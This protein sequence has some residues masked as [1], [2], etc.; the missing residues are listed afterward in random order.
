M[1][2]VITDRKYTRLRNGEQSNYLLAAKDDI[3]TYE[4][5]LR[6]LFIFTSSQQTPLEIVSGNTIRI[7]GSTWGEFGFLVGDTLALSI[8]GGTPENVTVQD[9]QGD[10]MTFTTSPSIL[11]SNISEVYPGGGNDPFTVNHQSTQHVNKIE[12]LFNLVANLSPANPNSFIDGEVNKVEFDVSGLNVSDQIAGVVVGNQSGGAILESIAERIADTGAVRNYKIS[13]QSANFVSFNEGDLTPPQQYQANGTIKTSVRIRTLR[14]ATNPNSAL[15][16]DDFQTLGNVGYYGQNYNQGNNPFTIDSLTFEDANGNPLSGIDYGQVTTVKCKVLGTGTFQNEFLVAGYHIPFDDR[17]KNTPESWLQ[18]TFFT[19]RTRV[20]VGAFGLGGAELNISNPTFTVSTPNECEIQFNT[21]PNAAFTQYF[22][23]LNDGD[24]WFRLSLTPQTTAGSATN[25]DATT[26]LLLEQELTA[27]PAVGQLASEVQSLNFLIHPQ[28]VTES[29][30]ATVAAFT[31]DDL[32]VKG[33]LNLNK[34]DNYEAV[35]ISFRVVRQSDGAFFNLFNRSI[36]ADQFQI[37][38]DGKRL[39]NYVEQLGYFL[40]NP[41]RNVLSLIFNGNED[42]TTY[43]VELRHTLLLSWRDWI[44]KPNALTDF[45]DINLPNNGLND[46]WVRYAVAGYD[47][48]LRLELV[49]DG[50]ADFYNAPI[51]IADYDSTSVVS[52]ID[53]LDDSNNAVPGIIPTQTTVIQADHDAGAAWS[54]P[55]VWGW[56]AI[57]PKEN[58]PRRII[59]TVWPWSSVNLPLQ[60]VLS[61]PTANLTFPTTD[62]ARVNA[63]LPAGAVID[64]S[65]IVARIGSPLT[66]VCVSPIEYLFQ[67]IRTNYPSKSGRIIFWQSFMLGDAPFVLPKPNGLCCPECEV[68][69]GEFVYAIGGRGI[70]ASLMTEHDTTCCLN[71]WA[72]VEEGDPCNE[73]YAKEVGDFVTFLAGEGFDMTFATTSNFDE[74]NPYFGVNWSV[75]ESELRATFPDLGDL[76]AAFNDLIR[77]G[78]YIFCDADKTIISNIPS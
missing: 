22:N 69:E 70:I 34:A 20:A 32:L 44:A 23:Q 2:I 1:S 74:I 15:T 21:T 73:L 31:E 8:G 4:I 3:F 63:Q 38:P 75:L 18:N 35:N 9:I 54:Q 39:F 40:P 68:N 57:R 29:G 76:A 49:K 16:R 12:V 62:V 47:F 19:Y 67:Q 52:A 64:E 51:T 7:V 30:V 25:N 43:E 28:D 53:L 41:G 59:S 58:E 13:I 50:V 10:L 65:T 66:P 17:Y 5:S 27:S 26:L 45:L 48:V 14:E 78:L 46:E 61:L 60:P 72:A 42:A 24:K 55:D 36:G 11:T 33:L 56:L 37:T 77:G 6:S 71:Q